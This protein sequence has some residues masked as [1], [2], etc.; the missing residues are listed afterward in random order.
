VHLEV[1]RLLLVSL[2][3]D[4]VEILVFALVLPR[5]EHLE[6]SISSWEAARPR[7][8][9]LGLSRS[10]LELVLSVDQFL[11]LLVWDPSMEVAPLFKD[12]LVPH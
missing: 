8:L 2:R 10:R 11:C 7:E 3:P 5:L 6:M 1:F 4:V 12:S 9:M